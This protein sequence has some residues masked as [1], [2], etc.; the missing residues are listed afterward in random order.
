[1]ASNEFY[2]AIESVP[3]NDVGSDDKFK[4]GNVEG[5]RFLFSI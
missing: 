5:H 4:K 1:M 2:D 3:E